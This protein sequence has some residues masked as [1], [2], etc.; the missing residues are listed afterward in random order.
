MASNSQKGCVQSTSGW[1]GVHHRQGGAKGCDGFKPTNV[2]D[3]LDM[4]GGVG[5]TDED[6][7]DILGRRR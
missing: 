2:A 7:N 1:C 3:F 6:L 4:L 5:V